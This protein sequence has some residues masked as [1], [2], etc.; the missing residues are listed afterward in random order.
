VYNIK[1]RWVSGLYPSSEI[2]N[3][4]NIAFWKLDLVLFLG[5]VR[6]RGKESR[7]VQ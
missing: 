5:D 7:K 2:L 4:I 6:G 3:T 1:N